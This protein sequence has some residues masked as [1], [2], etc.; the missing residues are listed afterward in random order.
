MSKRSSIHP[1]PQ[2]FQ[3]IHNYKTKRSGNSLHLMDLQQLEDG[4]YHA[5]QGLI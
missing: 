1:H 4:R 5:K 2:H 3:I